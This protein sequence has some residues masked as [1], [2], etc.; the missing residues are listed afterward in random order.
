MVSVT[1]MAKNAPARRDERREDVEERVLAAVDRLLAEGAVFTELPVQRIATESDIARSTFYRY[2]PDKSQL[3]IRMADLATD[4]LFRTA[5]Q[6]W[7][8]GEATEAS[9]IDAMREMIAGFTRH[10]LLLEALVEVSGYDRDVGGYWRA[11]VDAFVELVRRRLRELQSSGRISKDV[12]VHATAVVLTS[13]VERT[14]ATRHRISDGRLAEALGRA[15]WLTI[16]GDAP[17]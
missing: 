14:I 4:D 2:F 17:S 10:R 13:M 1:R 3:L 12:D 8:G 9:A 6:W 11:R 7:G 15:I 16:Y 5:A